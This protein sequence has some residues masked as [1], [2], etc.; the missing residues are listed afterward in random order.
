M[1]IDRCPVCPATTVDVID[2]RGNEDGS[3]I[4]RRRRCQVCGHRFTTYET[5]VEPRVLEHMVRRAHAIAAEM[6]TM[7]AAL[8]AW[9]FD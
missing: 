1:P 6:R 8:E 5:D 9:T 7:A 2:S 4:R 3:V